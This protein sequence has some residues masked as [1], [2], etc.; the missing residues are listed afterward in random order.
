MGFPLAPRAVTVTVEVP[1][2]VIGDVAVTVDCAAD[3][4]PAFT[5]TVAV[6]V[7]ATA[8]MVADTVLVSAGVGVNLPGP[9]PPP[10][11]MPTGWVTRVSPVRP[12]ARAPGAPR[13]G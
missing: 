12:R 4:V 3:T 9:T 6:C 5:T 7:M 1:P 13:V 2:A 11:G 10:S 8:L